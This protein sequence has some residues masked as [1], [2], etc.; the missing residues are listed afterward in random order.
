MDACFY[1]ELSPVDAFVL[2]QSCLQWMHLFLCGVVSSG[3]ICFYAELSPVDA[4]VLMQSCLQWMH[5][6]QY[7]VV[8]N[9]CICFDAAFDF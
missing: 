4:F 8:S 3:C 6:F 1:A 7:R 5:L 2:M 9:G